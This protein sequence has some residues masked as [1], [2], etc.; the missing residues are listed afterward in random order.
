M[1]GMWKLAAMSVVMGAGLVV[2]WQAQ[3][4]LKATTPPVGV[5]N[6]SDADA[7]A[8]NDPDVKLG[9]ASPDGVV[10]PAAEPE[11]FPKSEPVAVAASVPPEKTAEASAGEPTLRP[12]AARYRRGINFRESTTPEPIEMPGD[13][14]ANN[15]SST[16][17]RRLSTLK[18]PA[19]SKAEGFDYGPTL[20]APN[21][22]TAKPTIQTVA[23]EEPADF[24][25]F[26]ESAPP[27]LKNNEPK[28]PALPRDEPAPLPDLG[29]PADEP[30]AVEK[31]KPVETP[32]AKRR[33]NA[34]EDN[35]ADPFGTEP[36]PARLPSDL[37][38]PLPKTIPETKEPALPAETEPFDP[39]APAKVPTPA[40]GPRVPVD[41]LPSL[42]TPPARI[43]PNERTPIQRE[44]PRERR[45]TP[46][47]DAMIGDGTAAPEVPRGVLEPRLIIEKTA[48]AKALLGQPV[49]YSL[50]VKNVGTTPT[51]QVQIEDR[52]PRGSRLVGTAPRA[53]MHDKRLMWKLGTL[54]PNEERKISIKVVPEEEGTIGS[55]AKVTFVTELAADIVVSAPQLKLRVNGPS[56]LRMQES[57]EF[58]FTLS[59]PGDTEAKNV[60]LR[61]LIPEG[62]SHPAGSDLEYKIEKLAPGES[63]EVRLELTGAKV[64]RVTH[65]AIASAD[66]NLS[67]EA[68]TN[69]EIVGEQIVLTR[70][71]PPKTYVGRQV[72]VSNR[73]GNEGQRPVNRVR[74]TETI[75]VGFEFVEASD[76]GIFDSSTRTITWNV[77]PLTVGGEHQVSATLA[78]KAVGQ[79]ESVISATGPT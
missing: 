42:E 61:S 32:L 9:F 50:L 64:G 30:F 22:D 17:P 76:S 44:T 78:P 55:V 14:L 35:A 43:E 68:K 24:D 6:R 56:E 46:A 20:L 74:V 37:D 3:Q 48:P 49:V 25:P 1:S 77:G 2:V 13:A 28:L 54:Q 66:G 71:S 40:A 5:L 69:I 57:A 31:S 26:G 70:S 65:H 12:D 8:D 18:D 11:L 45:V 4:S 29:A 72:T 23:A 19:V 16:P 27:P 53:E 62:L 10:T 7:L 59:N 52:I 47:S 67:T 73:I 51:S 33:L 39:F 15:E 41:A 58:A 63:R 36:A 60:I 75:P 79:Y 21:S 38:T 34:A